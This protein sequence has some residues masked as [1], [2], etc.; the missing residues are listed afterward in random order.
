MPNVLTIQIIAL[1]TLTISNSNQT[2][3]K[4]SSTREKYADQQPVQMLPYTF[5]HLII[6]LFNKFSN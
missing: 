5:E 3:P 2:F 4:R 6:Y 1:H